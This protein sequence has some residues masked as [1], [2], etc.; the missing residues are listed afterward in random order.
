MTQKH[1]K[2]RM[3]KQTEEKYE[4]KN[5]IIKTTHTVEEHDLNKKI[6]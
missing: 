4:I 6:I 5:T 1:K 3:W 2:N